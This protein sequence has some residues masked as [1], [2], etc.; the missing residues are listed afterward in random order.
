MPFCQTGPP[1]SIDYTVGIPAVLY[2]TD[3][4]GHF[5][6]ML[7]STFS[8][9]F[10]APP[11]DIL[12]LSSCIVSCRKGR[13]FLGVSHMPVSTQHVVQMYYFPIAVTNTTNKAIHKRKPL[14]GLTV[15]EG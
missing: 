6:S 9:S 10:L 5:S 7:K 14:I 2:L 11:Q 1:Q 12:A 8:V 15:L 13:H 4:L 3:S